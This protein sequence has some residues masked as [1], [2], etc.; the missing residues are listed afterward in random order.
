MSRK[1]VVN[2]TLFVLIVIIPV[3]LVL[4]TLT[5]RFGKT[6]TL[7]WVVPATMVASAV[8][9][10]F[11][12]PHLVRATRRSR[13]A[14]RD[15]LRFDAFY[16]KF[17]SDSGLERES[18]AAAVRTASQILGLP[19]G[20]LRPTDRFDLEYRPPA[21]WWNR[22]DDVTDLIWDLDEMNERRGS[23]LRDEQLDTLEDHIRIYC[24]LLKMPEKERSR[25]SRRGGKKE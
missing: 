15:H 23:P 24:R 12:C 25:R 10:A 6:K 18:V 13:L 20:L 14:G 2:P 8:L 7:R 19:A 1:G 22:G 5:F 21:G 4:L 9:C 16:D 3:V 11:V 17:Y